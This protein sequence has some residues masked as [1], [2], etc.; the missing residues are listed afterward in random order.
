[1]TQTFVKNP[2]NGG[3]PLRVRITITKRIFTN[4]V[5]LVLTISDTNMTLNF[6]KKIKIPA[7]TEVYTK[8]Q[9]QPDEG[10]ANKPESTHLEC[11]M[12]E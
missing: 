2:I 7:L 6:C 12:E 8:K 11:T 10:E 9:K 3:I 1:M 5:L 4:T